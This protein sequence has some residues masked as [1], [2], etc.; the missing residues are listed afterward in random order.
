MKHEEQT[1]VKQAVDS[2]ICENLSDGK[3]GQFHRAVLELISTAVKE[4]TLFLPMELY[5]QYKGFVDLSCKMFQKLK[6]DN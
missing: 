3:F 1:E 6:S 4:Q 5:C 2:L